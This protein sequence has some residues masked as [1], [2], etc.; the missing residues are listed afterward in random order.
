MA[1]EMTPADPL[2]ALI[3]F[4][5]ALDAAEEGLVVFDHGRPAAMNRAARRLL[6]LPESGQDLVIPADL[7]WSDPVTRE[8]L[9]SQRAPEVLASRGE[10]MEATD[11]LLSVA[12][13]V[14]TQVRVRIDRPESKAVLV[15]KDLDREC[16]RLEDETRTASRYQQIAT[17]IADFCYE[18]RI[19][20]DRTMHLTWVSDSFRRVLGY[21]IEQLDAVG[22]LPALVHAGDRVNLRRHVKAVT[23][24]HQHSAE[25]RVRSRVGEI[26]WVRNTVRPIYDVWGEEIVGVLGAARE[27]S[28]ERMLNPLT[29]LP[30]VLALL[31]RLRMAVVR[32]ARHTDAQTAVLYLDFDH[33]HVY[34]QSL[35][36]EG[37]DILLRLFGDRVREA[38]GPREYAA[39]LRGDEFAVVL[40]DYGEPAEAVRKSTEILR[41]VCVPA[42]IGDALLVP[43][44]SAGLAFARSHEQKAED[45]LH[46]AQ[47]AATRARAL[48]GG[49][50]E[51]Y[52]PAMAT[53]ARNRLM[54]E[55]DLRAAIR[56]RSF[57]VHYQPIVDLDTGELLGFEALVR[58]QHPQLGLISPAHFVS[59]A[60]EV[61]LI[62]DIGEL[63][64]FDACERLVNWRA[65]PR[66]GGLGMSVNLS[67]HQVAAGDLLERVERVLSGTGL[68]PEA[69]R[70]ELTESA[71]MRDP[72]AAI[73]L[74]GSIRARGCKLGLDDFGTGHSSLSWLRR[75]PVDSLKIDRSFVTAM[76]LAGHDGDI[77]ELIVALGRLLNLDV[78]AEGVERVSQATRLRAMG[79]NL[80]QGYLFAPPLP[81]EEIEAL[82]AADVPFAVR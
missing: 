68:P 30:N 37:G 77:V 44:I 53:Q 82:L 71:A 63:V 39:H 47:T 26:L 62:V 31:D 9:G 55:G 56:N 35:G 33:F 11:L 10:L 27:I 20:D 28:A 61:G 14:P 4:R 43:S 17:I 36:F 81:P 45:L 79:C 40:T 65:K 51:I 60:E 23:N 15:L 42:A 78:I 8:P 21:T 52:E 12:D 5:A 41:A 32:L 3:L 58:M 2:S 64:L 13:Q 69:L 19:D 7:R 25:F 73:R 18:I 66:W 48:G 22:G 75:F 67:P 16:A 74:F 1:S 50:V 72:E 6:G 49:R 46:S 24:G 34:N 70:L 59:I 38:A 80:G 29:G 76:D 57:P 54:L